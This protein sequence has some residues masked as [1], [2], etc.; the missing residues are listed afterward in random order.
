EIDD[1]PGSEHSEILPASET[2]R[3]SRCCQ[4]NT[5]IRRQTWK[6]PFLISRLR[7]LLSGDA[8]C[9]GCQKSPAWHRSDL[10]YRNEFQRRGYPRDRD[11]APRQSERQHACPFPGR[12]HTQVWRGEGS[13]GTV[14]HRRA[15]RSASIRSSK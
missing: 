14:F 4:T 8:E 11:T 7:S 3:K 2:S 6:D 5:L 15:Q 9:R 12:F 10:T 13:P 1:S